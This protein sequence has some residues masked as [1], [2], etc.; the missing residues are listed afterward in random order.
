MISWWWTR[1]NTE[2]DRYVSKLINKFADKETISLR[3]PCSSPS[4]LHRLPGDASHSFLIG[5]SPYL[6]SIRFCPLSWRHCE[7]VFFFHIHLFSFVPNTARAQFPT[8][9]YTRVI[10]FIAYTQSRSDRCDTFTIENHAFIL[11]R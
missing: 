1:I 6:S 7:A 3:Q 10:L 8:G 4:F 2:K 11:T 5:R 9:D